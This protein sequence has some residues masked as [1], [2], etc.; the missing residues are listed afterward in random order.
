MTNAVII[1]SAGRAAQLGRTIA[2]LIRT[3]RAL[4]QL[5]VCVPDEE[6]VPLGALPPRTRVLVGPRGAA[7]Q[8]NH[9][10]GHL[11][12]TARYVFFFDDDC[13][14][15]TD[16]LVNGA[17]AFRGDARIAGI[18]GR[19]L[20]DGAGTTEVGLI[21]ALD[22]LAKDVARSDARPP[23][24]SLYGCNFAVRRDLLRVERF[25]DRLPLYSWLEDE[26]LS[27]RL[28]R[29]GSLHVVPDCACVHL[30]AESGGRTS[31]VRLGY[32]LVTNPVYLWR[33]GSI[34]VGRT[35]WL[36]ARPLAGSLLG[37]LGPHRAERADRLHGS[38]LSFA[39][40]I[41]GRV[42]PERILNL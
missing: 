24:Y 11:S 21:E 2:H 23:A 32:S 26:D 7:A 5:L 22:L 15:H 16:Y 20:K 19:V 42:T 36:V 1:A 30:G 34:T 31:H 17:D 4:D 35:V 33:K 28:A 39:D 40:L 29:H 12:D 3:T 9:A 25:D 37:L 6:S 13:L 27:R 14:V 10:L 8:R 38:L 41:R 18:T